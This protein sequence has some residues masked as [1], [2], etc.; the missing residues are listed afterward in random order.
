MTQKTTEFFI[1]G[2]YSKPPKKNYVTIKTNVFHI[3]KI[4][5][6][7]IL[8]LIYYGP[9]INGG[10]RYVLVVF[11][12]FNKFDWTVPLKNKTAQTLKDFFQKIPITSSRKRNLIESDRGK[13]I[14]TTF[15]KI[16]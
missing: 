4:W 13:E 11:D 8:D 3:D 7:D 14:L 12:N 5:C 16:C 10:F 15:F 6:L 9:K 1:E 2:T